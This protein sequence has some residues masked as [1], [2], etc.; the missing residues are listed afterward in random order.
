M[1]IIDAPNVTVTTGQKLTMR[2]RS[3]PLQQIGYPAEDR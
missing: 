1:R 2:T 3:S